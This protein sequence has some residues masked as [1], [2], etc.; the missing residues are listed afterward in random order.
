MQLFIHTT[1]QVCMWFCAYTNKPQTCH[2]HIRIIDGRSVVNRGGGGHRYHDGIRWV[3]ITSS[4]VQVLA[5]YT[6]A[7]PFLLISS[8]L[9]LVSSMVLIRL[10]KLHN[11]AVPIDVFVVHATI[12]SL[13]PLQYRSTNKFSASRRLEAL[14]SQNTECVSNTTQYLDSFNWQSLATSAQSLED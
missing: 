12:P 4:Q 3:N 8:L 5:S 10:V 6:G 13:Y 14:K 2:I 11:M 9:K 1:S 7:T